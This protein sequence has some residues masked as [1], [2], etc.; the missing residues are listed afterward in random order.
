M[1]LPKL[2]LPV[3]GA[4]RWDARRLGQ[5]R[6]DVGANRALGTGGDERLGDA[7][8]VDVGAAALAALLGPQGDQREDAV[9]ADE[10]PI[11]ERDQPRV[12][13]GRHRKEAYARAGVGAS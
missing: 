6:L 7:I 1:H 2:L 10:T 13:L 12:A 9:G 5:R 8:D 4:P 11:S 3:R